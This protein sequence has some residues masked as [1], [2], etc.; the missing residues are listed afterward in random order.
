MK[1]SVPSRA[2]R[3]VVFLLFLLPYSPFGLHAGRFLFVGGCSDKNG[4]APEMTTV[5][6]TGPGG[7]LVIVGGG[8]ETDNKIVFRELINRAGGPDKAV[9]A[10]IPSAGG[11]PVQSFA[12][13]RS[14][15]MMYGV[16]AA[17]IHL[18]PIAMIDDDSTAGVNES[19]WRNNGNN[20]ELAEMV[21]RCSGVWFT[22]GDQ[23]RTIRT[24]YNSDGSQTL[25]LKAVWDVYNHGGVIGGTSAGAAIMSK[26]MI[27]A[28][29]SV[30]ALTRGVIT[31]ISG[32][33]L[34]EDSG[35]FVTR[36][37][38]FF[39]YGIVDQHFNQRARIG[40][41][42]IVLADQQVDAE[43]KDGR[44]M[45]FGIDENTA[46]IFDAAV[47]RVQVAGA[48]GVTI[49][50]AGRA[51]I[52]TIKGHPSIR[53]LQIS[54]L[55][56]GDGFD[57]NSGTATPAPG[58]SP[59][60]GRERFEDLFVDQTGILSPT[61]GS[62]RELYTRYLA[63][64]RR[65]DSIVALTQTS[66]DSGFRLILRKSGSFKGYSAMVEGASPG[67]MVT[68]ISLDIEPVRVVVETIKP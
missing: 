24:L 52:K 43:N 3:R 41:L 60:L 19:E 44:I 17:N 30:A 10:V 27:A 51:E 46:I 21:G 58:K 12:W 15:L 49:V 18:I 47:D 6:K 37:L 8:L 32:E 62:F 33:D 48:G 54:Y 56:E 63:D 59:I 40:R 68:G 22:G 65:N 35:V 20:A 42:S 55:E 7:S 34:P 31:R 36:G 61:A 9:F 29:T 66:G 23:L 45:G 25:V 14:E 39:P 38:G 5:A 50:D 13:F 28:G 26:V 1:L 16:D 64:H 2:L 4:A 67:Y 11:T 53:N 57:F